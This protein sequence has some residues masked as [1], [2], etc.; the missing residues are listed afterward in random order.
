[1]THR[2]T[3]GQKAGIMFLSH[4]PADEFVY[5]EGHTSALC[6]LVDGENSFLERKKIRGRWHYKLTCAGQELAKTLAGDP[7]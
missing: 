5:P 1:M 7:A 3:E 6:N 2:V 4:C